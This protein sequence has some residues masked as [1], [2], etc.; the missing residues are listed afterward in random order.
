MTSAPL[1]NP[2]YVP[3]HPPVDGRIPEVVSKFG[4][5]TQ[6]RWFRRFGEEINASEN[7]DKY[8]YSSEYHKGACCS[9]CLSEFEDGY[10]G[11]GVIADGFCCCQD[12]RID[13]LGRRSK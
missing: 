8:Y 5:K 11:G 1:E 6:L 4:K 2:E 13:V 10:L 9:S 7:V 12:I 3:E